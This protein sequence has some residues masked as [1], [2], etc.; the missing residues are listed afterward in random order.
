MQ[1]LRSK[2]FYP[3]FHMHCFHFHACLSKRV[4]LLKKIAAAVLHHSFQLI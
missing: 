3:Q 2:T 1:H 4:E